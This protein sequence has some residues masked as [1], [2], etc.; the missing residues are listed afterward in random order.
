MSSFSALSRRATTTN[1]TLLGALYLSQGLPYGFFIQALP[2]LMR[3]AG[4]SLESIGLASLLALPWALKFLWAPCVDRYWSRALGPRRSWI[5]PLQLAI[6]AALAGA[7]AFEPGTQFAAL[8]AIV[9]IVNALSATQDIAT[10]ALAVSLLSHNERGV[11][12]GIQVAAYR[13]GMV[14]G[15]GV[16][17]MLLE[18]LGWRLSLLL[19]AGIILLATLP[20]WLHR[21]APVHVEIARPAT[22][23]THFMGLPDAWRILLMLFLFK[24]GDTLATTML[25]PFMVDRGLE[26]QDVA[27]ILGTVGF[28]GGLVGSLLGGWLAGRLPRKSALL[29]CAAVQAITLASYVVVAATFPSRASFAWV[30][31]I[32]HIGSGMATAALFTCMMDWCRNAQ[33]GTDY[34]VQAST[35]VIASLAAAA[36]SGFSAQH[37]GYMGHFGLALAFGVIAFAA[38]SVLFPKDARR[39]G[40]TRMETAHLVGD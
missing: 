12:N 29:L 6:A 26:L 2:V 1:L 34:T 18:S 40:A 36:A 15:G 39:T 33:A 21:E 4:E 31:A 5:L 14:L 3:A 8:F 19:M 11:G 30:V 17:L 25:R 16:L 7:A 27:W 28:I 24:F 32:E 35:V 10:D 37:L 20:T 13:L 23:A 22:A 38:V 9:L